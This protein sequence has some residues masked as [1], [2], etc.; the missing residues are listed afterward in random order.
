MISHD[1][2]RKNEYL[3]A[4]VKAARELAPDYR[5][6]TT[7]AIT[8]ER[9][10]VTLLVEDADWE[11]C[12]AIGEKVD[13]KYDFEVNGEGDTFFVST[14]AKGWTSHLIEVTNLEV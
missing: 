12:N 8:P 10:F 1:I 9:K 14:V 6:F 13:P 11:L 7:N 5:I 2:L 3:C 4:L